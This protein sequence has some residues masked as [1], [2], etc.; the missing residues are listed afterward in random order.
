MFGSPEKY[1]EAHKNNCK[2]KIWSGEARK[3]QE[4]NICNNNVAKNVV[5]II[6]CDI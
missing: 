2:A 3:Q 5:N 4:Q 6:L 1:Y